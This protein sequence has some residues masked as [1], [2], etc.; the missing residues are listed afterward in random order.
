MKLFGPSRSLASRLT[1][2][3]LLVSA[4]VLLIAT[5]AFFTYDLISFR[6]N[7]ERNLE[8]EAQM[9]GDNSI[10]AML[11]NDQQSAIT[12][13]A[14]LHHSPDVIGGALRLP[15]GRIFASYG[16]PVHPDAPIHRLAA[17]E[18]DHVWSVE[19]PRL[20]IAHRI[21]F[22]NKE[23]GS[24]YIAASLSQ[25]EQRA[26]HY[27]LIALA[28]F[29]FCMLAALIVSNSAR[30]L[31][32]QPISELAATAR[33][34]SRDR[35]YTV[36]AK[37]N[38]GSREI[39]TL[40][41]SFNTMLQQIQARDAAITEA[42]DQLE[43]RVAERTAELQAANRELEAFSYTVAHDLRGPLDSVTS[44]VY[45]LAQSNPA[46][47]LDQQHA[48]L[49]HL[50]TATSNMAALIDDLLH[51]A[52]AS[53]AP[54]QK[55]PVHLSKIVRE[56]ADDLHRSDPSRDVDFIIEDTPEVQADEGLMHI[57]LDNLLRNSWKY[58]SHH[59]HARIAFG[60]TS[61]AGKPTFFVRDD[62]AGFDPARME[63][64]FQPFQRLHGKSEFPGTGIGLATVQRILD[65][66]GGTIWATGAVEKGATFYFTL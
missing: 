34:V 54:I 12:T 21:V 9:I 20:L 41:S 29:I 15:D 30:K 49:E 17:G 1:R 65:R 2:M 6:A 48:M 33:T 35:D 60:W 27:A 11:F 47:S 36:R 26:R 62:G 57:V 3:N 58:T 66:Q 10:S 44:I 46:E 18:H 42:R 64:L 61:I 7:L 53:T 14:S 59:P 45:L 63:Q 16:P 56:I 23:V 25:I 40:V 4:V 28:I 52:R 55:E 13:L 43:A 39:A 8:A 24:V 22:Q 50:K 51:F 19:G 5:L 32:A 31:V 37:V 38:A